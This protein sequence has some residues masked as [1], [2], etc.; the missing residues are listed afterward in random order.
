[1]HRNVA[2]AGEKETIGEDT[3]CP[4]NS[5]GLIATSRLKIQIRLT[6]SPM[7]AISFPD[8]SIADYSDD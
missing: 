8:S 4:S 6:S 5:I 2:E 1:M 3:K 7:I